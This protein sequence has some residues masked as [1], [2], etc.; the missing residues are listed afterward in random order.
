MKAETSESDVNFDSI[1]FEYQIKSLFIRKR[2]SIRQIHAFT[3]I[4]PGILDRAIQW[5]EL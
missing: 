1:Q 4:I 3:R 2:F 5:A